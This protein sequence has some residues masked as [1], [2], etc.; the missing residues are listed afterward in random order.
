MRIF[1]APL[2]VAMLAACAT[3]TGDSLSGLTTP[4]PQQV[5]ATEGFADLGNTKL[6]YWD[7][8]GPGEAIVLLHP[9]SGSAEF[10]PYQ[11]AAFAK[12][13][14]RVISYSRRGQNG[15]TLGADAASYFA[16]DDLLGL[17]KVL[18][19]EKFHLVGNALGGYVGLDVALSHPDRVLSLVLACSMM[20]IAEPEYQHTLQSLRPKAFNGLP[21]EMKE[22]GPSYRAAN[23]AGVAEWKARHDRSGTRS[24]VRLRNKFTWATLA[25]LKLPTLL[26][27]GDA[28]LWIP[29]FLLKQ[30]G[31]KIPG[32]KVVIVPDAGHG[33][34]WEQPG[35][36][37][38]AVLA[39]IKR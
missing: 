32:S 16:A 17:M 30:V 36:F 25:G 20:G 24:P 21:T 13:G 12:A 39:F 23:P 35:F 34:Q 33:V 15:S 31:E 8:G 28:D 1:L 11:Q 10:Y 2:L 19:V 29:P 18:K 27:T 7:T 14:Y 37:N 3:T 9:G 4:I 22:L 5:P 38:A 26:I 6:W